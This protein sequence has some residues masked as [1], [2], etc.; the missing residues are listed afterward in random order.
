MTV[1]TMPKKRKKHSTDRGQ[2]AYVPSEV[3]IAVRQ[4]K[5]KYGLVSMAATYRMVFT[6][7]CK[8]RRITSN[9]L[10]AGARTVDAL[11]KKGS[12]NDR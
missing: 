2:L 12:K 10:F 7:F 5:R 11:R 9:P 4:I 1:K 8:A 6:Q 3:L